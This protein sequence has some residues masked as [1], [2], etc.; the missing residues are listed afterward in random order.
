ADGTW[1]EQTLPALTGSRALVGLALGPTG[2]V[3]LTETTD[4][5]RLTLAEQRPTGWQVR[6]VA[7]APRNGVLGFGGLAIGQDGRPLV[8][9]AYLPPTRK[10][11][12][13]LGHENA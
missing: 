12:P 9:Y 13:R 5:S 4:G 8:A 7:M 10:N 3:V 11:F 6:T 2:A 1:A